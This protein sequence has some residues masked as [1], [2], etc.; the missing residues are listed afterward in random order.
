MK[1]PFGLPLPL[2]PF[3]FHRLPCIFNCRGLGISR[4]LGAVIGKVKEAFSVLPRVIYVVINFKDLR[5]AQLR[6]L[7]CARWGILLEVLARFGCHLL[8]VF[9]FHRQLLVEAHGPPRECFLPQVDRL[10]RDLFLFSQ[11]LGDQGS[12]VIL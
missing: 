10:D 7:A 5:R 1:A 12:V 11:Q 4:V 9:P 2:R 6:L 8:I 3:C